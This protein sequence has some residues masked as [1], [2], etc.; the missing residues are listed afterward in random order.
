MKNDEEQAVPRRQRQPLTV[1]FEGV[2]SDED[3]HEQF[4]GDIHSI[5]IIDSIGNIKERPLSPDMQK[6]TPN[7]E[8]EDILVHFVKNADLQEVQPDQPLI[9]A[10]QLDS[11]IQYLQK[12]HTSREFHLNTTSI[13]NE[14]VVFDKFKKSK[15]NIQ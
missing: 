10:A 11:L 2:D 15:L 9:T 5:L 8:K 1:S 6:N 4:G 14:E 13:G 7:F 3:C 12:H